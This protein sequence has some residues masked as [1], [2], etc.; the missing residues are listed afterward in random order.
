MGF[1]GLIMWELDFSVKHE[2]EDYGEKKKKL[3]VG[4]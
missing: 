2:R 3:R 1:L 4:E